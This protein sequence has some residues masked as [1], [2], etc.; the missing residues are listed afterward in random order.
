MYVLA[1][2][3]IISTDQITIPEKITILHL[4]VLLI[5]HFL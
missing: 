4:S 5:L 3:I 2:E 1:Q